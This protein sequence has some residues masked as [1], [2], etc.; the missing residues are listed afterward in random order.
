MTK[1]QSLNAIESLL[2]P[3]NL[4]DVRNN[5]TKKKDVML[6][7]NEAAIKNYALALNGT[8]LRYQKA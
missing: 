3:F 4:V 8:S 7:D 1:N 5:T 6:L 2:S